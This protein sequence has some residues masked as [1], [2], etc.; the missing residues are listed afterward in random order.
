MKKHILLSVTSIVLAFILVPQIKSAYISNTQNAFFEIQT[1]SEQEDFI[2]GESYTFYVDEIEVS[3]KYLKTETEGE[4]YKAVFL[5]DEGQEVFFYPH[6]FFTVSNKS[7]NKA[8]NRVIKK[9]ESVI[10]HKELDRINMHMISFENSY[11]AYIN[12][13]SLVKDSRFKGVGLDLQLPRRG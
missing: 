6:L 8:V 4:E 5:N 12:Y 2:K 11:E 3:W 13:S 7:D 10:D 9:S 1:T